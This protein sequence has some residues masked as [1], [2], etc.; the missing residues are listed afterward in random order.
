MDSLA[1]LVTIDQL[2]QDQIASICDHTF[3]RRS[4][5]FSSEGPIPSRIEARENAF[6]SFLEE[7][8]ALPHRP[9]AICIRPEDVRHAAAFFKK[10]NAPIKIVSVV[11]FPDGSH[12][13]T[14]LKVAE[15]QQALQDGASEIDMVLNYKALK[16]GNVDEA[17]EDVKAIAT[18]VHAKKGILKLILE[19]CELTKDQII[20]A[21]AIATEA[22]C[23]FIK[24][25]TGFGSA[26]ASETDLKI[27][28]G[29]FLGGIKIS[30]GVTQNSVLS[31][32]AAASGRNDGKIELDPLKIRIGESG[33]LSP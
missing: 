21:A 19:T 18:L 26:G 25:S 33:L 27:M 22:R 32:L 29:T 16:N 9:Y 7:T 17:L 11:G 24:T 15:T 5:S 30:G 4:E 31:L 6:F 3:L 14:N 23:D 8:V 20:Q 1:P 28:R 12:Y 2:T 13:S 10:K